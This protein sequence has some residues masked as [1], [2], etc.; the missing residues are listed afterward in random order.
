MEVLSGGRSLAWCRFSTGSYHGTRGSWPLPRLTVTS[1]LGEEKGGQGWAGRG[2]KTVEQQ[3]LQ[4][5]PHVWPPR[6][7]LSGAACVLSSGDAGNSGIHCHIPVLRGLRHASGRGYCTTTRSQGTVSRARN[8]PVS[9]ASRR[10]QLVEETSLRD[11]E[12]T[13]RTGGGRGTT[14]GLPSP[15]STLPT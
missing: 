7:A 9:P 4:L 10:F 2:R 12:G 3:H 5:L 15:P 11:L 14:T 1:E 8:I 13:G 6:N